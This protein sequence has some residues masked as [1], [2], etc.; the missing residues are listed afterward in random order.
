MVSVK[1]SSFQE[2]FDYVA[3]KIV[4]QGGFSY[5][6]DRGKDEEGEVLCL[7]R[8][9]DGKKCAAGWLIPDSEY[10]P[11]MEHCYAGALEFFSNTLEETKLSFVL[12]LQDCHDGAAAKDEDWDYFFNQMRKLAYGYDINTKRLDKLASKVL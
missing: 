11:N 10:R 2:I 1:Y 12:R 4:E 3:E 7:Y 8:S 9:P 5:D 6:R